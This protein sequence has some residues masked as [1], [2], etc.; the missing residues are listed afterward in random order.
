MNGDPS[1]SFP[2]PEVGLEYM[3]RHIREERDKERH[4]F[5]QVLTAY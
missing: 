2:V 4:P 3:D 5:K 1:A